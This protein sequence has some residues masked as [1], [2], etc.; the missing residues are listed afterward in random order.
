[1]AIARGNV[2]LP[3]SFDALG[4]VRLIH[5]VMLRMADATSVALHTRR[6]FT[7]KNLRP[8]QRHRNSSSRIHYRL[9]MP[10][11]DSHQSR[12]CVQ[13]SPPVL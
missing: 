3:R 2:R 12:A 7:V 6:I 9:A 4:S 5:T 1:M 8:F 11:L 13:S 10:G